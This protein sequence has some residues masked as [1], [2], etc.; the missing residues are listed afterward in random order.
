MHHE[1]L[2]SQWEARIAAYR[3]SGQT[4]KVWCVEQG[5]KVDQLKYWLY[6]RNRSVRTE[7]SATWLPVRV[8]ASTEMSEEASLAVQVGTA[9]IEIQ[10]GFSATLLREVVRALSSP[11]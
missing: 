10:P 11:C 7:A 3:T 6:K 5:I 1:E 2:Q 9:R 8:D 4:M